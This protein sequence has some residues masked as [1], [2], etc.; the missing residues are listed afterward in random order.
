MKL[1][2]DGEMVDVSGD[3]T[4]IPLDCNDFRGVLLLNETSADIMELLKADTTEDR[5][6]EEMLKMYNAA[7]AD[8]RR[9]VK[10]VIEHLRAEDLLNE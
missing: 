10:A 8:I 2:Y 9:N 4:W 7:E 3:L 6:V 5:I 1:K